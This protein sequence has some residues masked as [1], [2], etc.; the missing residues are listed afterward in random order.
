MYVMMLSSFINFLSTVYNALNTASSYKK[1]AS[2]IYER[3]HLIQ[4]FIRISGAD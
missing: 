4:L 2:V 3:S 1:N